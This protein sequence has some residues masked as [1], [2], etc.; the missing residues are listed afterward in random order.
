MW[1][2]LLQYY[3]YDTSI[4]QAINNVSVVIYSQIMFSKQGN[5][6]ASSNKLMKNSLFS[7]VRQI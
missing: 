4:A 5:Y 6:R 2:V 3:D 1:H 7:S